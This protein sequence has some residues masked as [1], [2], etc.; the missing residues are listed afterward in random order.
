VGQTVLA[1]EDHRGP[2]GEREL[3]ERVHKIVPQGGIDHPRVGFRCQL[4]FVN[5]DHFF[6]LARVLA[7]EVVGNAKEPG[8]EFGFA[9]EAPN[10]FVGADERFLREIV[11]ELDIA[12]SELAQ[13][14][15]HRRLM[16]ANQLAK[17]V[18]VAMNKD[19]R[20][21]VRIGQ[22]HITL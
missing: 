14:T 22:L 2:F 11:G 10:V 1:A 7:K 3:A 13:E 12:P 8:R 20:K 21:Q 16:P 6:A 4:T 5:S 17:S 15:A 19:A 18:L 9:S